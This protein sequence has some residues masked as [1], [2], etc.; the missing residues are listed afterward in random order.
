MTSDSN[1]QISNFIKNDF[2]GPMKSNNIVKLL[3]KDDHFTIPSDI[4]I[5]KDEKRSKKSKSFYRLNSIE[6]SE[7]NEIIQNKFKPSKFYIAGRLHP[8]GEKYNDLPNEQDIED[9][10]Y[11]ENIPDNEYGNNFTDTSDNKISLD[12]DHETELNIDQEI[13]NSSLSLTFKLNKNVDKFS[14]EFIGAWY[15]NIKIMIVKSDKD[16]DW[17]EKI[18]IPALGINQ[19]RPFWIRNKISLSFNVVVENNNA[20]FCKNNK[21]KISE[22][23]DNYSLEFQIHTKKDGDYNFYTI[24]V[25]NKSE[26]TNDYNL[27]KNIYQTK[28]LVS[29]INPEQEFVSLTESKYINNP[30]E[31][32]YPNY[33]MLYRDSELFAY[34]KN[35]S[36]D[37]ENYN[38]RI[39]KVFTETFPVSKAL[40]F[41]HRE[42]NMKLDFL[43]LVNINTED[44]NPGW[45][46]LNNLLKEYENW[47]KKESSNKVKLDKKYLESGDMHINELNRSLS[48]MQEG[49][50]LIKTDQNVR[51]AFSLMNKAMYYQQIKYMNGK[52]RKYIFNDQE[53]RDTWGEKEINEDYKPSWRAFQMGFI[54]TSLS[55]I[56]NHA[57]EDREEVDLLWFPTGGGKTEAYLGLAA[58]EILLRRIRDP[59]DSGTAVI[60]RYTLRLLTYQQFQRCS[61]LICALEYM[62]ING[63]IISPN[64]ISIGLWVGTGA[65]PNYI[66]QAKTD[67]DK[68]KKNVTDGNH[69]VLNACPWC[70]AEIGVF[71]RG[72]FNRVELGFKATNTNFKILCPD[73][74][75]FFNSN[76][77][78]ISFIDEDLYKQP[79]SLLIGTVDKFARLPFLNDQ[80]TE[81]KRFFGINHDQ[82]RINEP[83]GLI[84]QDELHLINGPLGSIVGFYEILIQKLCSEKSPPKIIGSTATIKNFQ[85]QVNSLFFRENTL[86]FPPPGLNIK[87]SFFAFQSEDISKSKLFLGIICP[88]SR[89]QSEVISR[90]YASIGEISNR[91][92]IKDKDNYWTNISF[93]NSIRELK[94]ASNLASDDLRLF[95]QN[96]YDRNPTGKFDDRRRMEKTPMVLTGD[97]KSKKLMDSLDRLN[98]SYLNDDNNSPVG[99]CL[100]SNVIE[101]G[102]DI[103]RLSLMTVNGQPKTLS[104]YIQVTG[105]IGRDT[106]F[107]GIVINAFNNRKPRD[108]AVYEDFK[109]IHERL[110]ADIEVN[111]ITPFSNQVIEIAAQAIMVA[112][113]RIN[114]QESG[115]RFTSKMK[116]RII[117]YFNDMK[118]EILIIGENVLKEK[119]SKNDLNKFLNQEH[120]NLKSNLNKLLNEN[121]FAYWERK[122]I[123]EKNTV[124]GTLENG[125]REGL[126]HSMD[127]DLTKDSKYILNSMR[128]VSP[129][130][131]GRG[132]KQW[133]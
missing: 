16:N 70:K 87:D 78:P 97:I 45:K 38:N 127:T 124:D 95:Y 86:V 33:N 109:R 7:G 30:E 46:S 112:Y 58:F 13:L 114:L 8:I 67:I 34:S 24:F 79:P 4:A 47:I 15:K 66:K 61:G 110:Y 107:P 122:K 32:K 23:K 132:I 50:N 88:S 27:D 17:E 69:L 103:Q 83:P 80:G 2:I 51:D 85:S 92:D 99:I 37:W 104:Q 71:N 123:R 128:S 49:I 53:K 25:N 18:N 75:C 14:T 106:S 29:L 130:A 82:E 64:K 72:K 1:I 96:I 115:D 43:E 35:M 10:N 6:D 73:N 119:F 98:I 20:I 56:A 120:E 57:D 125:I 100:A 44:L 59:K 101:V 118:S 9:S 42:L 63:E 41:D 68:M 55:S 65:S 21:T 111:S 26:P 81:V 84:I 62:R 77:L 52:I 12:S 116:D 102:L 126:V 48:R 131:H 108:V 28:L 117:N 36:C 40:P 39:T 3:K 11:T 22:V 94:I 60:M 90:L 105:R 121:A 129:T 113:A 91:L 31:E 74:T 76:E 19:I 5:I 133:E 89:S 54:L 93:F